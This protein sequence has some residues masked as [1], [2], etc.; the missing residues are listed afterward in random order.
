M[1]VS[2]WTDV[3]Q[4]VRMHHPFPSFN[5]HQLFRKAAVLSHSL[6]ISD[7]SSDFFFCLYDAFGVCF[8]RQLTKLGTQ[9]YI[10]CYYLIKT[11]VWDKLKLWPDD[12][13]GFS[14]NLFMLRGQCVY[15]MSRHLVMDEKFYFLPERSGGSLKSLEF[16]LWTPWTSISNC[17]PIETNRV[18]TVETELRQGHL[19]L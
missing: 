8:G 17:I 15:Q 14:P 10:S 7:H 3:Y 2:F 9:G 11:N 1:A 13:A 4:L 16:I 18:E 6:P 5:A 12:A 19:V